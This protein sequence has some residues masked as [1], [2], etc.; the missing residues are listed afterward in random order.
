MIALDYIFYRIYLYYKKKDYIPVTMGI[1]FIVV[2]LVAFFFVFA[3]SFNFMTDGLF[4]YEN[5]D[6]RPAKAIYFSIFIAMYLFSIL[7]YAKTKKR[8]E[9]EAKFHNKRIN[10]SIKTWQIF[11]SPIL[12]LLLG[13][14]VIVLNKN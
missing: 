9:L 7:R 12:V 11:I 6:K 3:V 8:K 4:T 13:A 2:L 10:K 1:N 5:L 14:L